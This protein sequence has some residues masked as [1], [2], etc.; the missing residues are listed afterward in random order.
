MA[1]DTVTHCSFMLNNIMSYLR[2]YYTHAVEMV[3]LDRSGCKPFV[4]VVQ[5]G[6]RIFT[7]I[8]QDDMDKL[9]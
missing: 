4:E 3:C 7:S 5:N 6:E 8:G 9:R 2:F 1:T